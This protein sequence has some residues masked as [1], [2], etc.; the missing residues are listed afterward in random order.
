MPVAHLN[1]GLYITR[2]ISCILYYIWNQSRINDNMLAA[3]RQANVSLLNIHTAY[4]RVN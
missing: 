2:M 4:I 3:R 1:R